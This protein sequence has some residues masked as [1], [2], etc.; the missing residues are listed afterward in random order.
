MRPGALASLKVHEFDKRT[1]SLVVGKDKNR[2]Q[3]QVTMP[4]VTADF[5][6]AQVKDKLPTAYIFSRSGGIAWD[7]DSWKHPIKDAS[8]AASLPLATCAYTLRHSV[9]TDLVRQRLPILTVAQLAGTSVAMI[10]KHYGHLVRDDAE[11]AL[12]TLIV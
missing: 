10:E 7:K 8:K 1:R 4:Q 3:R 5:F 2:G 11:E 9:I 6:E 12:A